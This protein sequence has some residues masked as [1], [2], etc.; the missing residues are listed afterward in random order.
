MCERNSPHLRTRLMYMPALLSVR[1]DDAFLAQGSAFQYA[2]ISTHPHTYAHIHEPHTHTH[3]HTHNTGGTHDS[4]ARK[5]SCRLHTSSL[6]N[7]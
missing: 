1:H 4:K 5:A 3:T 7:R 6:W 2:Y